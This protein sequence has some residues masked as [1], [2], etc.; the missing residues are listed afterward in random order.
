MSVILCLCAR[1]RLSVLCL[2]A[3]VCV[4]SC[5]FS[6]EVQCVICVI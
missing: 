6:F 1:V 3:R 4:F 2:C 5:V